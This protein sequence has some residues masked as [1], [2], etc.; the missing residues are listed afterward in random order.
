MPVKPQTSQT[1]VSCLAQQIGSGAPQWRHGRPEPGEIREWQWL[2][3]ADGGVQMRYRLAAAGND[4]LLARLHPVQEFAETG[5]R[6][7]ETNS[8]HDKLRWS[9]K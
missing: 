4:H 5:F 6:L 8:N 2:P 7:R 1:V 9:Y 3:G